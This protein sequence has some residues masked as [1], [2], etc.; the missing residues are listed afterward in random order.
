MV[1]FFGKDDRVKTIFWGSAFLGHESYANPLKYF[2]T[3]V[4]RLDPSEICQVSMDRSSVNLTFYDRLQ[5]GREVSGL[6]Q[7]I[8]IGSY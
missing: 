2:D 6:S 5:N 4:S 3:K 1:H 7:L 8:N